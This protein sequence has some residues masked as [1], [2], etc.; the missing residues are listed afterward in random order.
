MPLDWRK[1]QKAMQEQNIRRADD[2]NYC[3]RVAWRIMHNWVAVQIA[4]IEIA[5][6]SLDQIFLP[7]GLTKD[8]QTTI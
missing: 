8:G 5:Q 2:D 6:V 4:L 3:Y 1:A 7:Y